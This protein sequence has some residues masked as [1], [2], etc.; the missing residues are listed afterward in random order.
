VKIRGFRIELGEIEAT[1]AHHPAVTDV[2]VL[3]REAESTQGAGDKRLVAYLVCPDEAPP[4]AELR[5]FLQQHL[6]DYMLPGAFVTLP[7]FP[8]NPNGK[9]DR[10]ALLLLDHEG[11][12]ASES[13]VA[14]RSETESAIAELWQEMLGVA[15]VGIHDDFFALGG[16]SLLGAQFIGRLRATFQVEIPLRTVFENPTVA[17]IARLIDDAVQDQPDEFAQLAALLEEV[18]NLSPD[19]VQ[20]L[21][22]EKSESVRGNH[23]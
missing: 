1:L 16:H 5:G 7:A 15:Q 13:Y 19:Q 8:L 20:T 9:V 12:P 4:T 10:Q 2:I 3:A 11:L 6:P 22:T 23:E 18:E 17:G 14:P 21:L